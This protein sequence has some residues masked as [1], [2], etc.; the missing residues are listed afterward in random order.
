[1][2]RPVVMLFPTFSS[3]LLVL[4][5]LEVRKLDTLDFPVRAFSYGED[6]ATWGE[7]FQQ[8]LHAAGLEESSIGVEPTHLRLLELRYLEAAAPAARYLSA[9]DVLADLRIIKDEVEISAM[10]EAVDI[11]QR[12]LQATLPTIHP[13]MTE[14]QIASEL[15]Q[16]L[17]QHGSDPELPF[18]PI[19]SAGPNSANPH[20]TPTDRPLQNGDLLV[21]DWGAACQ[22]YL[23]DLTRTFAIGPAEPEFSRI[24]KL[25]LQA[26]E[27]GRKAARPNQ[28]AE[29]IDLAARRVIEQA[30]YGPFFTHRTGHGIGLEAHEPPYIRDGNAVLLQ[31]GN[32]FTI[33]PGIYLPGRGGVRIEDDV[34]ITQD[35]A[36]TL[37]DLPRQLITIA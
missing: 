6:P 5:Q 8:A 9:E 13:G 25:V 35:G 37:S 4:P 30:G 3:P 21:I 32:T 14:K 26:N 34:L 15:I 22:G 10:R 1:M 17:Y 36:E 33:E 2:E 24:A 18:T 23:S 16:Q 27:A 20:A 12:A 11:A 29:A 28:P 31:A 7:V 19:V